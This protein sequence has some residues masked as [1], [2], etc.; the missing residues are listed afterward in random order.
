M[1]SR[2]GTVV[3]IEDGFVV[4]CVASGDTP[5]CGRQRLAYLPQQALPAAAVGDMVDIA[6]ADW[7]LDHRAFLVCLPPLAALAAAFV[8]PV[9]G[10]TAAFGAIAGTLIGGMLARWIVTRDTRCTTAAQPRTATELAR[11]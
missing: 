10:D 11:E 3:G 1:D 2:E 9:F 7:E 6:L 5:Q 4:V 8:W